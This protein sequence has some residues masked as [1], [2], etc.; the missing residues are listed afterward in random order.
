[1]P[2]D[3]WAHVGK[4]VHPQMRNALTPYNE[5]LCVFNLYDVYNWRFYL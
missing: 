2:I 1:M 5:L 4:G 3:W